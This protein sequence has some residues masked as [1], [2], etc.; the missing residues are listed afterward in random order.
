MTIK[1][2]K[3]ALQTPNTIFKAPNQRGEIIEL[4]THPEH[5]FD[6]MSD[7]LVGTGNVD[8]I[9]LH[10]KYL[11]KGMNVKKFGPTCVTLYT[12]DML[13]KK[14]VAKIRYEDVEIVEVGS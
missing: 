1:E 13:G 6:V 12:F 9:Y 14:S 10:D 4:I 5:E 8:S 7:E 11:M 3:S 2:I